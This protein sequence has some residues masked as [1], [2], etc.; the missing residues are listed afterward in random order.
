MRQGEALRKARASSISLNVPL[1]SQKDSQWKNTII[2]GSSYTYGAKG[3]ALTCYA[4]VSRRY[5][6]STETPVT[7]GQKYY[8]AY[9]D[10][11][12]HTSVRAAAIL[13]KNADTDQNLSYT[14]WENFIVGALSNGKP[15]VLLTDKFG[16][17]FVVAY[18]YYKGSSSDAEYTIYIRDPEPSGNGTTLA[19]YY[20]Y[21][22]LKGAAIG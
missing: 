14:A 10:P 4:M 15:V 8:N 1:L 20:Q 22:I 17:H 19:D 18:G 21:S 5:G 16:S 3:C 6:N 13:G 2:P 7:F 9:G 12:N 11:I